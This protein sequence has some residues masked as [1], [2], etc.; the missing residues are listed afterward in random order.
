MNIFD[1]EELSTISKEAVEICDRKDIGY[2]FYYCES[3][4]SYLIGKQIDNFYYAHY[5]INHGFIF[6]MSKNLPWGKTVIINH[7]DIEFPSEPI[8]IDINRWI[9][10]FMN[11]YNGGNY[12][13]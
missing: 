6:D 10:G 3:D 1:D 9:L 5:H 8:E 7:K 11:K 13:R 4:D 2:K 12:E